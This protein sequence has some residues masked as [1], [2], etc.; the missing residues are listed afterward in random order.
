M[1]QAFRRP[2]SPF[3]S[4]RFKLRGL[5]PTSRYRVTNFDEPSTVEMTGR[6]LMEGG[7]PV[8][9]NRAPQAAI[10]VYKQVD[11]KQ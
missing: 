11:G 7:L 6:E 3:E 2:Q 9:L 8:V 10:I 5:E 1:V 4:A